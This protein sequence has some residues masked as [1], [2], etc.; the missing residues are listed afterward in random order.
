MALHIPIDALLKLPYLDVTAIGDR[1]VNLMPM[2]DGSHWLGWI[3][4]DGDLLEINV[5]DVQQVDYIASQAA[6]PTDM[7]IE[8]IEF[9]WQRASWPEI[10]PLIS[11]A[12]SDIHNLATSLA[13]IDYFFESRLL[14]GHGVGHFVLTEIEYLFTVAR[15]L[16]DLLQEVVARIWERVQLLDPAMQAQKRK[17]PPSF[18][19][20]LVKSGQPRSVEELETDFALPRSL[21]EFYVATQ[22]FFLS[23]R[24]VRD[25]VVHRGTMIDSVFVTDRGF[26]VAPRQKPYNTFA[27]W[28]PEHHHNDNL[29]SLRPFLAHVVFGTIAACNFFVAQVAAQ[30]NFPPPIAPNH[31]VFVRNYHNR[32]LLDCNLVAQGGSPWWA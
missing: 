15:S 22:A 32:A 13:K 21:A 29:V 24:D 8:F 19:K 30:I 25:D 1:T 12:R 6:T 20:V 18:R 26:C 31:R 3:V 2:W 10:C 14:I 4:V 11:R 9:M 28:K 5:S 16:F 27:G 17:L 23:L 7:M